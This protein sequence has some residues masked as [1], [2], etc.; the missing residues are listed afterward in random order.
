MESPK[1]MKCL[2]CKTPIDGLINIAKESEPPKI[3]QA[4]DRD[5]AKGLIALKRIYE[6]ILN[7]GRI[8]FIEPDFCE[9]LPIEENEIE[10]ELPEF[11]FKEE[12][13]IEE[14]FHFIE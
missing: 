3:F 14:E 13:T 12:P 5:C 8:D 10:E 2:W 6:E 1:E 4:C 9:G 11:K 7:C